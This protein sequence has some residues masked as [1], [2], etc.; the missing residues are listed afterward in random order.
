MPRYTPD[1]RKKRIGYAETS[2]KLQCGSLIRCKRCDF[3]GL[4]DVILSTVLHTGGMERCPM[5]KSLHI[6]VITEN[7]MNDVNWVQDEWKGC[8][9]S[10]W[11]G[12]IVPDA[13]AHPAKF[14]SKLIR[15]IYTHM[16]EEGWVKEGDTVIDPFGGIALGALDAMR[17]GLKWRG[18]E[19]EAKFVDLGNW[20]I[21]NWNGK[22]AQMPKWSRDAVLLQGDS[23]KLLDVLSGE[24]ETP[25]TVENLPPYADSEVSAGNVGGKMNEL[26]GAGVR[27]KVEGGIAYG[28]TAGQLDA[29]NG[30]N[31]EGAVSS[32]PYADTPLTYKKNGL[33]YEGEH[34]E[35]PYMEGQGDESYGDTPGQLGGMKDKGF[36]AAISSPPFGSGDSGSA[37]SLEN[38]IDK[39][40]EWLK[41][42]TGWVTGYGEAE[43]QLDRMPLGDFDAAISSP[44]FRHSEGGSPE[45][46]EGGSIDKAL[47]ARHAAG[48]SAADGYGVTAGQLANMGE[49]DF[50]GAVSSPPFEKG[51]EGV[52]RADKFKDPAAFARVQMLKGNGASFEAK[53]RAMEKDNERAEYGNN[54]EQ[55][56][57]ETGDDFWMAARQ[58]VEQVYLAL[59]PGAH[60]CWVVKGFVKNKQYVDFPDQWRQLC[61]AVGFVTVHEHRA[62]LVNVKGTS[63]TLEGGSFVH[64]TESKSFFRRLAEKKGSPRVDWETV[65]CMVKPTQGGE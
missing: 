39:S 7:I 23:R 31:F 6:E 53:M 46:K 60:A 19:L 25:H 61:E 48:N 15:R 32:P 51:S 45:P 43:G 40:A 27:L 42:N 36:R 54:E 9:P 8:Y 22:F 58:I 20:N 33:I 10:Q 21:S 14:S 34:Y 24:A 26:W 52:M 11:K 55:L 35:R 3:S 59:A 5:C 41:N 56:A 50:E 57:D 29:M 28:E 49:G 2:T 4:A 16:K 62:L 18:V 30:D 37:N 44:P 65:W 12:M 38:R 17:L 47:Y 63:H 1:V 13:M 64:K